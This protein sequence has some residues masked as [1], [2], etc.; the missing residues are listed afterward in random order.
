MNGVL[1]FDFLMVDRTSAN[2]LH[3][4]ANTAD[5]KISVRTLPEITTQIHL[6]VT[7]VEC[8]CLQLNEATL[9]YKPKLSCSDSQYEVDTFAKCTLLCTAN[10][11]R[12][13]G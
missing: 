6:D 5:S 12:T 3:I 9:V 7:S 11:W 4:N 1:I 8:T 10:D 2:R 13:I